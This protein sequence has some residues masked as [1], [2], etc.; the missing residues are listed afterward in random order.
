VAKLARTFVRREISA[1]ICPARATP[2]QQDR[3]VHVN[4]KPVRLNEA[5][6]LCSRRDEPWTF[7]RRETSADICLACPARAGQM[8]VAERASSRQDDAWTFVR[9]ETPADICLASPG[10]KEVATGRKACCLRI[11]AR[12]FGSGGCSDE[13]HL[14]D[15]PV[16]YGLM[17]GFKRWSG[18]WS[19]VGQGKGD[20]PGLPQLQ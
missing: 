17:D 13:R 8:S 7:V 3:S 5:L 9:P 18:V 14:V 16:K 4:R 6:S 11:G 15:L 20:P 19:G 1:D 2:V 10:R 12:G